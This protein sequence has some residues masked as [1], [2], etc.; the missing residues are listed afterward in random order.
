MP[1]APCRTPKGW[2]PCGIPAPFPH[3]TP[4]PPS[5]AAPSTPLAHLYFSR[6]RARGRARMSSR[7]RARG[8]ARMSSRGRA[9]GHR[10]QPHHSRVTPACPRDRRAQP[11]GAR[12]AIEATPPRPHGTAP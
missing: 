11:H 8:R 1:N 12:P 7:G 2:N 9:R 10:A 3:L 6:G 5:S 4:L